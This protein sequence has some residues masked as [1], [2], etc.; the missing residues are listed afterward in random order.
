MNKSIEVLEECR[1]SWE[2]WKRWHINDKIVYK[3]SIEDALTSAIQALKQLEEARSELPEIEKAHTYASENAGDYIMHENGQ[4]DYKKKAEVVVAKLRQENKKL[5]H[6]NTMRR[7]EM[8][9]KIIEKLQARVEL[10]EKANKNANHLIEEE[11]NLKTNLQ[12]QLS[13]VTVERVEKI[14]DKTIFGKA[15]SGKWVRWSKNPFGI[16]T[17]LMALGKTAQAIVKDIKEGV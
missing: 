4:E 7:V 12:A 17:Y 15:L 6:S 9:Q 2:Q 14:L 11:V 3:D 8:Q 5:S 13:R 1:K 10:L 16:T